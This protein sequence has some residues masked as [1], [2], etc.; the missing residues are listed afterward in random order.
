MADY[1]AGRLERLAASAYDLV[2][3]AFLG[4]PSAA[5]LQGQKLE[6]VCTEPFCGGLY[7][8]KGASWAPEEAPPLPAMPHAGGG[9][10]GDGD[11]DFTPPPP[12]APSQ[13]VSDYLAAK[14]LEKID[15]TGAKVFLP[16]D[17]PIATRVKIL[18]ANKDEWQWWMAEKAVK[19][20]L[21]VDPAG[22][23]N[24][25]RGKEHREN[26]MDH[27]T[28]W[29]RLDDDVMVEGKRIPKG[30]QLTTVKPFR[31]ALRVTPYLGSREQLRKDKFPLQ[32]TFGMPKKPDLNYDEPPGV[33]GRGNVR[34][35][36]GP[37]LERPLEDPVTLPV[38]RLD[39]VLKKPREGL[40]DFLPPLLVGKEPKMEAMQ[41]FI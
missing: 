20:T 6:P 38:K 34:P 31:D 28:P 5:G 39:V 25:V 29:L 18:P 7:W 40:K 13:A 16:L 27:L 4:E 23:V 30:S 11:P 24:F 2:A 36:G 8:D 37:P 14:P 15:L 17:K 32:L 21:G 35:I 26:L 1:S 10:H 33:G 41:D 22:S 9:V 3:N 12:K 19:L